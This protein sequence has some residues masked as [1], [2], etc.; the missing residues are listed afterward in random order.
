[1]RR[2]VALALWLLAT[3]ALATAYH[4]RTDGANSPTCNGLFDAGVG[5]APNCGFLLLDSAWDLAVCGDTI[6]VHDGTHT[7][8]V[9]TVLPSLSP[10]TYA[11]FANNTTAKGECTDSN[12]II[13]RGEMGGPTHLTILDGQNV[14][15]AV[16]ITGTANNTGGVTVKDLKIINMAGGGPTVN[17]I[18]IVV[19]GGGDDITLD[20]L[21]IV[22]ALGDIE[23]DGVGALGISNGSRGRITNNRIEANYS[24]LIH[25]TGNTPN[26]TP[27]T[28]RDMVI[29][30][31]YL[32]RT[33]VNYNLDDSLDSSYPREVAGIMVKRART[34]EISNNYIE[35]TDLTYA[36]CPPNDN[37]CARVVGGIRSRD[38]ENLTIKG[39]VIVNH[40]H[41][42]HFQEANTCAFN[43]PTT[44]ACMENALI[45]NNTFHKTLIHSAPNA[46]NKGRIGMLLNCQGCTLRNNSFIV[47]AAA[48]E[49]ASDT[50]IQFAGT[51]LNS[52]TGLKTTIDYN[53]WSRQAR[54]MPASSTT[55]SCL[56]SA[57][58]SRVATTDGHAC[59]NDISNSTSNGLQATGNKPDPYYSVTLT[60][61]Q[62]NAGDDANCNVSPSD[63]ECDIAAVQEGGG[64]VVSF[65]LTVAISG[66]GFGFLRDNPFVG[67]DCGNNFLGSHTDCTEQYVSGTLVD[68][69]TA[70]DTFSTGSLVLSGTGCT[71]FDT[72]MNQ[73]RNCT[74]TIPLATYTLTV[75][76]TGTGTGT[77][78]SSPAGINCGG[79]C[80]EAYN[81][82]TM[83]TLSA[84]PTATHAFTGWSGSGCNTQGQVTIVQ[85]GTCTATFTTT[86]P[87]STTKSISSIAV[88]P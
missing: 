8:T 4:I 39:N 79:D 69:V 33:R 45:L 35:D 11:V 66:T 6:D 85:D 32:A 60:S 57:T 76:K 75:T 73:A 50:G 42:L 65:P 34:V 12:R 62:R 84:A 82:G 2:L 40:L 48:V 29:S 21:F 3:P 68:F 55:F 19:F 81:W 26:S 43:Q 70:R 28:I 51:G 18:G 30:G 17:D 38:V 87:T 61:T 15:A 31:N 27:A 25:F 54:P 44:S 49:S 9:S 23:E 14:A 22:S 64:G 10:A 78:T 77:V 41:G 37:N 5:A 16:L 59:T 58:C 47:D 67:I 52:V 74:I 63:G 1:M 56:S 13:I 46:N 20:N 86:P 24:T 71:V 88:R 7:A 36:P 53:F 80:T 83:V 72:L